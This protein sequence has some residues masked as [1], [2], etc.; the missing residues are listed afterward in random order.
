[1]GKP[2]TAAYGADND[3]VSTVTAR[4]HHPMSIDQRS[5]PNTSTQAPSGQ[6]V[7]VVD[8]NH[9]GA[10][11]LAW[12][13]A[14]DGHVVRTAADAEKALVEFLAFAPTVVLLDIG[15]PGMSGYELAARLRN[16]PQGRHLTLIAIT[17]FDEDLD[18]RSRLAGIDHRL[19]KPVEPAVLRRLIE[20]AGDRV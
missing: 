18:D 2:A 10:E 1:M 8:D 14:L 5:S 16:Q 12:L 17:G 7:M 11:S 6:R 15:L 3:A 20:A 19:T 9:D 13:L 4:L